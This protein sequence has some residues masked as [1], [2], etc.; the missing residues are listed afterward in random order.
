MSGRRVLLA[1]TAKTDAG[2]N[3]YERRPALFRPGRDKGFFKNRV[4]RVY[5][6]AAAPMGIPG[7]PEF[8][9]WTASTVSIRIVL[10]QS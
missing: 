9:A 10:T 2:S 6:I 7:W 8:A 4:Q 5:A 3:R 1:G